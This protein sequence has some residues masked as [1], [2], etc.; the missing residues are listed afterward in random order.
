MFVKTHYKEED[1]ILLL[2]AKT[3]EFGAARKYL[4]QKQKTVGL[5]YR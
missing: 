5:H 3:R 4:E 1:K 2:E